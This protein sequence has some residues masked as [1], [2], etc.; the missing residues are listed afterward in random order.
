M[1]Q[2]ECDGHCAAYDCGMQIAHNKDDYYQ[3]FISAAINV[4]NKQK[5]YFKTRDKGILMQSK[6]AEARLDAMIAEY[7]NPKLDI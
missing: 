1:N 5:A 7:L 6:A 4:R 3:Q 2:T